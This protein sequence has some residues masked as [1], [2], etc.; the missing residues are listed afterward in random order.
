MVIDE[1]ECRSCGIISGAMGK[2]VY[3][4]YKR[5][6]P[7]PPEEIAMIE[8]AR[9]LPDEADEDNPEIDPVQPPERDAALMRAEVFSREANSDLSRRTVS[10]SL[11]PMGK[12]ARVAGLKRSS[13]HVAIRAYAPIDVVSATRS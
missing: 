1:T 10:K 7:L 2:D 11:P 4:T 13:P 9:N 8:A 5:G 3:D 6:T 12:V